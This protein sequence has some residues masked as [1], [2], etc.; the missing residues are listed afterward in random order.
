MSV[1][2]DKI[3]IGVRVPMSI[4]NAS[5]SDSWLPI[6]KCVVLFNSNSGILSSATVSDLYK[7]SRRN[8]SSQN[9][10][11]FSGVASNNQQTIIDGGPTG[12][13]IGGYN[14]IYTTGSLL[15][16]DPVRDFA[17]DDWLSASSSGAFNFQVQLTVQNTY[18]FDV[19]P[20]II[21]ITQQSGIFSTTEGVSATEVGILTKEVVLSTRMNEKPESMLMESEFDRLVGGRR[22]MNGTFNN[23]SHKL[24]NRYN[25]GYNGMAHKGLTA[26]GISGGVVS[27]GVVSGG[28]LGRYIR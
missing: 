14:P 10:F 13:V 28:R 18:Y 27:G 24:H 23:M 12:A 9:Y 17:L 3:I 4:Q 1:V 11:E 2:P 8:G 22:H 5:N 19:Q 7:L 20:E 6:T 21:I 26:G 25:T 16:L 15:V